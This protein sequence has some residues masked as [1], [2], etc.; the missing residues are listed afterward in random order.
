MNRKAFLL[1]TTVLLWLHA[2]PVSAVELPLTVLTS[3]RYAP[4]SQASSGE[5][6]LVFW[7]K[8]SQGA[9]WGGERLKGGPL[10]VASGSLGGTELDPWNSRQL[11]AVGFNVQLVLD[12]GFLDWGTVEVVPLYEWLF[13]IKGNMPLDHRFGLDVPFGLQVDLLQSSRRQSSGWFTALPFGVSGS[14]S[15]RD[16]PPDSVESEAVLYYNVVLRV[17]VYRFESSITTGAVGGSVGFV[18][19]DASDPWNARNT[20]DAGWY[21]D[22]PLD[23]DL[24]SWLGLELRAGY[25]KQQYF[26]DTISGDPAGVFYAVVGAGGR[27]MIP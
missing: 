18:G 16:E 21:L 25:Q 10:V 2:S 3:L 17:P 1:F 14:F 7:Y 4:A 8:A 6:P 15:Y 23:W 5:S 27:A 12:W 13:W 26:V 24:F 9:Y 20:W 19:G 11:V 22:I